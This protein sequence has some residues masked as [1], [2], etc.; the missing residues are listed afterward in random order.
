MNTLKITLLALAAVSV[1]GYMAPRPPTARADSVTLEEKVR[2]LEQRVARLERLRG[3]DLVTPGMKAVKGVWSIDGPELISPDDAVALM[4]LPH[5][6]PEEYILSLR[7]R[8]ITGNNTFAVGVP[9][10]GRQVLVALDAHAGTISGLEYL[11]G[12]FV[13]ENEATFRGS[14]F[15]SDKDA[16]IAITV[17]K[18]RI[19]CAFDDM[20]V[21]DWR[22]DPQRLS[23]PETFSVPDTKAVFLATLG[24]RYAISEIRLA[25]AA[26]GPPLD[27]GAPRKRTG[28]LEVGTAA[29][30]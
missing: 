16:T 2:L 11:D 7:V 1:A 17:R 24:S 27:S 19:T 12:R 23:L 13:H 4:Q 18:D 14:L 21:V 28:V 30:P 15:I 9:L 22:G 10:G 20:I 5:H 8:R 29:L 6:P 3:E 25:A 26:A